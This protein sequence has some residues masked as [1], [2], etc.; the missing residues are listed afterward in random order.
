MK[1]LRVG[2][3][4]LSACAAICAGAAIAQAAPDKARGEAIF[5]E[6]CQE[7]HEPAVDRAPPREDLARKAPADIVT[8]L[9]TG[10]MAPI[11]EGLTPED[12][13]AIAAYLT[14]H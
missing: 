11:A 10:P 3:A 14:S 1:L 9:T 4:G 2:V 8:A 12:K 7:C 13:L 6:R 5:R